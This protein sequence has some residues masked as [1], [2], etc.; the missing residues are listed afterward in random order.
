MTQRIF[1]VMI[2]AGL[3]GCSHPRS[4]PADSRSTLLR[5]LATS[6]SD[7]QKDTARSDHKIHGAVSV[8]TGFGGG[9]N[10]G[11]GSQSGLGAMTGTGT[12]GMGLTPEGW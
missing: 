2:L 8:G 7:N 4:Q 3:A 1:V 5:P 10:Y 9:R 6:G 12:G 11:L